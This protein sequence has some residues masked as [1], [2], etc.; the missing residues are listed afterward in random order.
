MRKKHILKALSLIAAVC[1]A[2]GCNGSEIAETTATTITTTVSVSTTMDTATLTKKADKDL[3]LDELGSGVEMN[4]KKYSIPL[5]LDDFDKEYCITGTDTEYDIFFK[6]EYYAFIT[7][8][9][10]DD[11][12]KANV[13]TIQFTSNTD[14]RLGDIYCGNSKKHIYQKYGEPDMKAPSGKIEH[15]IFDNGV[16]LGIEYDNNKIV[17]LGIKFSY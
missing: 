9:E 3:L 1:I 7:V 8:D 4:G 17:S 5:N 2:A 12:S 13:N 15:Y 6:D 10:S 16:V 11:F 14:F